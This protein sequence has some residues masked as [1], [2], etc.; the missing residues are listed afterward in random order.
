MHEI[1]VQIHPTGKNLGG[2]KIVSA[3]SHQRIL[4]RTAQTDV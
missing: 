3:R 2:K 1:S 4:Q